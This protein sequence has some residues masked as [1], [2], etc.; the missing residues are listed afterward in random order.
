M[1][2]ATDPCRYDAML[3][4]WQITPQNRPLFSALAYTIADIGEDEIAL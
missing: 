3:Q 2:V 4:C 1:D